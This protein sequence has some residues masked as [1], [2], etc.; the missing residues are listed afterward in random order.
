MRTTAD[1][2]EAVKAANLSPDRVLWIRAK[3]QSGVNRSFAVE[4]ADE[5][6][7]KK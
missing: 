1:F 7:A 5:K 4:L 6:P 3:T 2:E